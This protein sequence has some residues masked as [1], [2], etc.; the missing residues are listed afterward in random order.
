MAKTKS[1]KTTFVIQDWAANF[2]QFNG[3]FNFSAGGA[4]QGVPMTFAS[5]DDAEDY[6]IEL[7]GEN[8]DEERSEYYVENLNQLIKTWRAI[9]L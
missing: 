4:S 3:K 8:Y 2:L 9:E 1:K 6:L 5:R 7:L